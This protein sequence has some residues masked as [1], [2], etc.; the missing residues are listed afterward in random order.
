M[1]AVCPYPE[2]DQ[3]S[4]GSPSNFLKIHFNMILPS[5]PWYSKWSLFLKFPH[6]NPASISCL[7]YVL[8]ACPSYYFRFDCLNSVWWGIQGMRLV[9]GYSISCY[10]IPLRH[11]YLSNHP[12]LEQCER[13]TFTHIY[14]AVYFALSTD[15]FPE[16]TLIRNGEISYFDF[17][18]RI[19]PEYK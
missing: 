14:M 10:F 13:K 16:R 5:T 15:S 6:L 12:I 18:N 19:T 17:H 8:H 1:P 2:T 3:L 11:K 9:V 4:P 7:P